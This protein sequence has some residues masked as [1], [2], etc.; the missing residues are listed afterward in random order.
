MFTD[1]RDVPDG[2]T[3]AADVCIVGAGAAGIT[4]ARAL[5]SRTRRV[6]VLESGF[7]DPEPAT[8]TLY[9][10]ESLGIPY[11]PLGDAG[12]RTRQYGGSTNRWN[13]EC[14]PLV[15]IDFESRAWIPESGWP[16]DLEHLAP[17]YDR[18]MT[19]CEIE[20]LTQ[21]TDDPA[22]DGAVESTVIQYSPPTRFGLA[23]HDE[24]ASATATSVLLGANAVDLVM[25]DSGRAVA[26]LVVSTIA[27]G[28]FSVR[29]N[30]FVLATGGIEN[31]RLL[32]AS[33][34]QRGGIG[35][36]RD[37]VGRT[38][39][40][41]LYL[42]D[43]A[44]IALHPRFGVR[45][46]RDQ[47]IGGQRVRHV[48]AL[49]DA[50]QRDEELPGAAF[51]VTGAAQPVRWI[52]KVR[53]GVRRAIA[54][55][56]SGSTLSVKHIQE[57]VPN[58]ES[59]VVLSRQRDRLGSPRADLEWRVSAVDHEA[60]ARS[61]VV[62][63]RALRRAG[64]GRVV[65]TRL[66]DGCEWPSGLR[67]ARHHMGTTRMHRDPAR[68]VVDADCRV[69]GVANLY[70]AGSSVFPTSGTANPTLTIVALALRLADHLEANATSPTPLPTGV[71]WRAR[72]SGPETDE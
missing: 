14:R 50:T 2:A 66:G 63:D 58:R 39:M 46:G 67:G 31:A 34:G 19:V 49:S 26:H 69:H 7:A 40:E 22:L 71:A 62:L 18:A 70:V 41:H 12:T 54:A 28:R 4:I 24:L 72:G 32:L 53:H 59:R 52:G 57:Q 11:F 65:D 6:V 8:Q 51:V 48:L 36:A 55:V 42:D 27:G 56:R 43:A 47:Q 9:D 23:A 45:Y 15:A 38:F 1:A 29:A 20:P 5:S 37:R 33:D 13:G 64:I 17:Y 10:G 35:N 21:S 25:T 30:A 61:Y 44:R 16:F 3:L 68:G 60:A